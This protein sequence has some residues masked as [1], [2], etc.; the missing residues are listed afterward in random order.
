[1]N[2]AHG[3]VWPGRGVLDRHANRLWLAVLLCAGVAALW[4]SHDWLRA[5]YITNDG[6]QYLDAAVNLR[7]GACLCTRVAHFDDQ[8]AAGRV[9]VELTH[10]PPGYPL[11]IAAL[12][13]FGMPLET[14]GYLISAV[15]FLLSTWLIRHIAI[16]LGARPSTAFLFALVWI[17]NKSALTYASTVLTESLFTA[18]IMATVAL[19]VHDLKT[20]GRRPALLLGVGGLAG[21][22]YS[23]RYA[24]LFLIPPAMLYLFWRWRRNRKTLGW[25][26]AGALA[27]CVFIVP[28]QIHN[29]I[30]M[31]SWRGQLMTKSPYSLSSAMVQTA[32]AAYHLVLGEFVLLPPIIWMV[33]F[34]LSICGL[35]L[36]G[37]RAWRRG[38]LS[39]EGEFLPLALVWFGFLV[40]V[41]VAGILL[42]K[43]NMAN[44]NMVAQDLV[45]YYLPIYPIALASLAGALSAVRASGLRF[46][47]GSLAL[48]V[49]AVNSLSFE[50][51]PGPPEHVVIA[52]DL[53]RDENL[54]ESLGRWLLQRVPPGAVVV[55]EEGQALH[56][57]LQRPVVSIIEP[58]ESSNQ[59]SDGPAFLSLMSQYRSRYLLLF[60]A[61]RTSQSSLPFLR[62][63]TSG[64]V[65]G[66]LTLRVR[67]A[68]I[69]VYECETCA[70]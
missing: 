53:S 65:P 58:P 45:R 3:D 20:D 34:L 43:A 29:L 62:S 18:V 61:I 57:A 37:L 10:Y 44:M 35:C 17:G 7:S 23:I 22:A 19:I 24:G 11:L 46:A 26:L 21:A 31:G 40:L 52:E 55:S 32:E 59:R 48:A 2:P 30:F 50:L 70:Q 51:R 4:L 25:G 14:A 8:V 68:D 39:G 13:W 5:P 56:Y 38:A 1:M 27:A 16:V 63:L 33:L 54:G 36:L 64:N 69:T 49:L 41:Y 9:P 28:I 15:G 47:A 67:T 42:A 66:W 60:P 12:S 6:Y